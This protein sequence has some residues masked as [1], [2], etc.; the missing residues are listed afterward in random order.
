MP[1]LCPSEVVMEVALAGIRTYAGNG[2]L[3]EFDA[4]RYSSGAALRIA[5]EGATQIQRNI[6]SGQL[7][8][9][10]GPTV[11]VV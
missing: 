5:G 7:L 6:I 3:T 1:N 11:R 10:V 8:I 4:E 9:Q 2:S